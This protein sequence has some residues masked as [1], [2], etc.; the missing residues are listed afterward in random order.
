MSKRWRCWVPPIVRAYERFPRTSVNLPE[1]DVAAILVQEIVPSRVVPCF[2][3]ELFP[4]STCMQ[5]A[6]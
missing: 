1:V 4:V 6:S 3:S 5:D 2:I